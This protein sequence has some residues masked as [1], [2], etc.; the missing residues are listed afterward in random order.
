M[1]RRSPPDDA[2]RRSVRGKCILCGRKPDFIGVWVANRACSSKLGAPV[3]KIRSVEY[4][5]CARC[6]AR[7]DSTARIERT[8]LSQAAEGLRGPDAN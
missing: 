7:P 1:A 2:P 6:R 5:V 3:G 4:G 8:L